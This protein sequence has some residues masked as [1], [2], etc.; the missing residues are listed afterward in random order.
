M[1]GSVAKILVAAG[2]IA[3][4]GV[5]MLLGYLVFELQRVSPTTYASEFEL[6]DP[7]ALIDGVDKPVSM[8]FSLTLGLFVLAGFA[9]KEMPG[10]K[11][12]TAATIVLCALFVFGSMLSIYMGFMA[13]SVALYYASFKSPSSISLTGTFTALQLLGV[14]ISALAAILLLAD[15]YL[16][17]GEKSDQA[18]VTGPVN[19]P[20]Y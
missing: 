5:V 11:R 6:P 2:F 18:G 4:V 3:M 16:S 15:A 8:L 12:L 14:G 1:K 20:K 10:A 19:D 17:G 7:R 9:L 13:K